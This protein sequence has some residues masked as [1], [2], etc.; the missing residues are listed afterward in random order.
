MHLAL[1]LTEWQV[2]LKF[3]DVVFKSRISS[4]LINST[5]A[6]IKYSNSNGSKLFH[7]MTGLTSAEQRR[8]QHLNLS[9]LQSDIN[10]SSSK[11]YVLTWNIFQGQ[12]NPYAIKNQ[13]KARNAPSRGHFVQKPLVGG[14]GCLELVLYGIRVLASQ[15]Y[16][17][18]ISLQSEILRA[19]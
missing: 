2:F 8:H 7:Q 5:L 10:I 3:S 15:Q 19:V 11:K 13:R 14:F 17:Q 9:Y 18:L 1:S 4:N 12:F 16:E 6:W